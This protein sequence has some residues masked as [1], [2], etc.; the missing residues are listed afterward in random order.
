MPGDV[1]IGHGTP[2]PYLM[3]TVAVITLF[4][5]L[6]FGAETVSSAEG[7]IGEDEADGLSGYCQPESQCVSTPEQVKT[8]IQCHKYGVCRQKRCHNLMALKF[9]GVSLNR[10][11]VCRTTGR[12]FRIFREGEI[13]GEEGIECPGLKGTVDFYTSLCVE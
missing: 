12:Y 9:H 10:F 8:K 5:F 4:S 11:S 13:G 7:E 1:Q 6:Q 2:C 3:G